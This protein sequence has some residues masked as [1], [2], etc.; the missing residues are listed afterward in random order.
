[1]Q[2]AAWLLPDDAP[3]K[4]VV[5]KEKERTSQPWS[6]APVL[7]LIRSTSLLVSGVLPCG[8]R[9]GACLRTQ[10]PPLLP[11]C[12]RQKWNPPRGSFFIESC[13]TFIQKHMNQ[14]RKA[15]SKM[16]INIL[17]SLSF[18]TS[19]HQVLMIVSNLFLVTSIALLIL[20]TIPPFQVVQPLCKSWFRFI[21]QHTDDD[22]QHEESDFFQMAE[23]TFVVWFT[24]EYIIRF[25]VSPKKVESTF[26]QYWPLPVGLRL[27]LPERDRPPWDPPLLLLLDPQPPQWEFPRPSRQGG[28]NLS[29]PQDPK[30]FQALQTH[31]WS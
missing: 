9:S 16:Q 15:P 30:D 27:R 11:R 29:H 20:S 12:L 14:N 17:L 13:T 31:Y 8:G 26:W 21:S 25:V 1:M 24:L 22:S 28:P 23:T 18:R 4:E 6:G 19:C 5:V 2:R 7:T 3:D 10:T